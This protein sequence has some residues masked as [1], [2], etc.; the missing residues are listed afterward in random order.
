MAVLLLA[1]CDP[2][3]CGT[4]FVINQ[5]SDTLYIEK[6]NGELDTVLAPGQIAVNGPRCGLGDGQTPYEMLGDID[7]LRKDTVLCKKDIRDNKNWTTTQPGKYDY[8][9]RFVVTDNDF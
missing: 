9:H 6:M 3:T 4:S 7:K 5:T 8:E 2:Q 1:S